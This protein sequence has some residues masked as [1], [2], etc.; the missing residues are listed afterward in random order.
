[1]PVWK[2]CLVS[3]PRPQQRRRR[4]QR[5]RSWISLVKSLRLLR[6]QWPLLPV[7]L[8]LL[9]LL[10][11]LLLPLLQQRRLLLVPLPLLPLLLLLGQPL[12]R[13]LLLLQRLQQRLQQQ[14]RLLLHLPHLHRQQPHQRL[15]WLRQWPLRQPSPLHR[16]PQWQ[17]LGQRHRVRRTSGL[18]AAA[19]ATR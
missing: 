13:L 4:P 2:H 1:M 8:L 6:R 5:S 12:Q 7:L 15:Q 14:H 18:V 11:L 3:P 19:L 16:P 17:Q 9:L 10:P